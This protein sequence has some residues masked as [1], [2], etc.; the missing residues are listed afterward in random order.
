MCEQY[1]L[2]EL[3]KGL[4][5]KCECGFVGRTVSQLKQVLYTEVI[6]III[7]IYKNYFP[8]DQTYCTFEVGLWGLQMKPVVGQLECLVV[9]T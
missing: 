4:C 1:T 8:I 5:R 9:V 7:I 6:F 3:V 2:N